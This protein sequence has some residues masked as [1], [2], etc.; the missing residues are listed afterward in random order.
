MGAANNSRSARTQR[1]SPRTPPKRRYMA[2]ALEGDITERFDRLADSILLTEPEVAQVVGHTAN[3]LK[4]WRLH[5][6]DK[7]PKPVRMPSDSIRYRVADVRAWL[8]NLPE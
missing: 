1:S 6:K 2:K 8:A 5:G 3:T 7:G 4:H